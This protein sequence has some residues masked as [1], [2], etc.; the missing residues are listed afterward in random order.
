MNWTDYPRTRDCLA[1]VGFAPTTRHLTPWDDD[2]YE[3]WGLNEEYNFDWMKRFTRWFQIH[4][5]WDFMR[6]NNIN[7]RNHPHWLTNTTGMCNRCKGEGGWLAEEGGEKKAVACPDCQNGT[8][9]PPAHR[10][11][12]II[13][14][15]EHWDDIPNSVAF[16]LN[17]ATA[18]LPVGYPYFTSSVS[19]M[20]ILAYMMGFKR[21][22]LYGFEMGTTTEYHYQRANGEYIMGFLQGKGMEVVVPK[23]SSLLKGELYGYKN[24]KTGFR[25]NLEMRQVIVN[26]QERKQGTQVQMMTGQVKELEY[27]VRA[28]LTPEQL[29]AR[30]Q[31][32]MGEYAKVIGLHNV[33]KG[34]M[35]E[36]KNMTALYD[37]YFTAGTEEGKVLSA[38]EVQT[39]VNVAYQ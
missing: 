13:Y 25:Q 12:L 24:M 1:I 9:T 22:E 19:L 32:I 5:R 18:L 15:Q 38:E 8:Y 34:A 10:K 14:M 2:S 11:D 39:F 30:Y 6:D 26:E 29:Q 27:I 21:V 28:G 16:P 36:V 33:I 31:E 4:P 3:I 37:S 23:N 35:T 20:L 17:E 7:H